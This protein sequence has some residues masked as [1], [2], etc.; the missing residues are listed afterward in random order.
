MAGVAF[1]T[2]RIE[3]HAAQMR[4]ENAVIIRKR[5]AL[6]AG[7]RRRRYRETPHGIGLAHG[8]ELISTTGHDFGNEPGPWLEYYRGW[9]EG[10][11]RRNGQNNH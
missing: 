9:L 4:D 3:R 6:S 11:E 2:R 8:A 1:K 7:Q 10:K 5:A